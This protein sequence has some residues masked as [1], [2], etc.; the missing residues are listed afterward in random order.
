[1]SSVYREREGTQVGFRQGG[2]G[3][4]RAVL[5]G[6][7]M[8]TGCSRL[9][10]DTC[11]APGGNQQVSSRARQQQR[12]FSRSIVII[13][14]TMNLTWHDGEMCSYFCDQS[15]ALLKAPITARYVHS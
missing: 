9:G 1:M 3:E 8:D 10:D 13:E 12:P 5:S 2:G 15:R 7:A 6:C 11:L 14:F 4:Q